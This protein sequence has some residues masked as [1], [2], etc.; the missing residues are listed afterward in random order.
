MQNASEFEREQGKPGVWARIVKVLRT[1]RTSEIAKIAGVSASSVSDWKHNRTNPSLDTLT[2]IAEY[3][4]TTLDWLVHESG[5][6]VDPGDM[7]SWDPYWIPQPLRSVLYDRAGAEECH[8]AALCIRLLE[9][10]LRGETAGEFPIFL[11]PK[12]HELIQKL[13]GPKKPFEDQVRDLV[14]EA[15]KARGLVTDQVDESSLVFFGDYVPKMVEM[16]LLGEIAA[17]E[18][19]HVFTDRE[20]VQVP[21]DFIKRGKTYFVLRVKG[22]SMIEDGIRDGAL[23][24]CEA[25]QTAKPGETI[26]ALIDGEKATVK[27]YYP[28]RG[29]IRLQPA[30]ELHSPIYITEDRLEIQGA[31]VGIFHRPVQ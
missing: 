22:E 19:L 18:P 25:K 29:R 30:N 7:G 20:P 26:V 28:E 8:P 14:L 23:I 10:A 31:V 5:P 11:G 27:R 12:E 3:G 4:G 16:P 6:E 21:Q 1:D 15:L 17:G 13:A 9:N 2:R 24:V